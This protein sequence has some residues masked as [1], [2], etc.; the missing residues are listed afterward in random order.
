[1]DLAKSFICKDSKPYQLSTLADADKFDIAS[2]VKTRDPRFEATFSNTVA[3]CTQSS[4]LLYAY[5]FSD[6]V[7][8]TYFNG[9]YPAMYASNTNVNDAPVIRYAEIVLNWIEAKAEL[10]TMGEAAV[11]QSD[12]DVSVNAIRNRPLDAIAIARGVTKTAPLQLATLTTDPNKDDPTISDL[13]WEIRRERRMEFVFEFARLMDIRR[14]K[15]IDYM[16]YSTHP[17]KMLGLWIDFPKEL[18]SFLVTTKIGKLKVKDATGNIVTYNGTNASSMVGFYIPENSTDR[19]TFTDRVYLCP[20][21]T[22]IIN[23]YKDKGY[24]LTQTAGW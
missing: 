22:S 19:N 5:K 4:S 6:R 12:I 21:G 13:M 17:E 15:K 24:T 8:P 23:A 2:M 1:L 16:N 7:S 3:S 9:V 14:W 10:A 18:P 11:T 20:I